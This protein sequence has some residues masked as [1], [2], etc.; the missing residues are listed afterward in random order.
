MSQVFY[1]T[2]KSNFLCFFDV[3]AT[4]GFYPKKETV[5]AT[6]KDVVGSCCLCVSSDSF[7]AGEYYI[8]E[9]N[10]SFVVDNGY[11]VHSVNDKNKN[12]T[13]GDWIASKNQ[14]AVQ[15]TTE[16]NS[17]SSNLRTLVF[18][19]IHPLQIFS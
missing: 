9:L 13:N 11:I 8:E 16:E 18:E 2:Y 10:I 1:P 12:I 14:E 15:I 4:L 17:I 7:P 3:I 5:F 6:S 19:T